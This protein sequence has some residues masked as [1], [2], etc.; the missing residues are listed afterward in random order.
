MTFRVFTSD[1]LTNEQYH[2]ESDHVSGSQLV[3]LMLDC[4]AQMRYG[5]KTETQALAFGTLSHAMMLEPSRFD[6][7]FVRGVDVVDGMMTSD[8]AIKAWLSERGIKGGSNKKFSELCEMVDATGESPLIYK[9]EMEKLELANEGKTIVKPD[10]YDMV[11]Q[12][13]RVVMA[14]PAYS[15][16]ITGGATEVSLFGELCGVKVKVRFDLLTASGAIRDY[17]TTV[18]ANPDKFGRNAYDLGYWLKMALQHD[19]FCAAYGRPPESVGLLAQSKKA[20]YIA[21]DF[22][23][24]E[25]QLAYGRE[26]YQTALRIYADCK[27]RDSWPAYGGGTMELPTPAWVKLD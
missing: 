16:M 8:A 14:D 13:R 24:T 2:E 17:K 18:S 22:V 12:M 23:L 11:M 21:Q 27:S 3:E 7:E 25:K 9:C 4:P 20:P 26:Q 10:E 1:Q 15:E 5:E 6:A 19:M